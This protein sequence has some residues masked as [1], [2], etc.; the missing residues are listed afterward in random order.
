MTLRLAARAPG[1]S[2]PTAAA[3]STSLGGHRRRRAR[4]PPPRAARGRARAARP[5]LARLEPLLDRADGGARR[6]ALGRA[7]AARSV[8]L[9]LGRGGER[10][11]AEVRAQGDRQA[12]RRRARGLASTAA[13][14]ARSPSPASRRS[15]RAFEPLLAGRRVRRSRTTSRRSHAAVGA[16]DRLHPARADPGRG[17]RPSRSSPGSS[18]RPRELADEH[19]ALLVFDEMQTGVGRTGT[20]LRLGAARRAP[21]RGHARQGARE[22]AADRLPARRRRRARG[23]RARATTARTFGGNP[24]ACAAAVAVCDALTDELL[25]DVREQGARL[26]AGLAPSR[27]SP[28]CAAAACCS[29]PSSTARPAPVVDAARERGLLV[30]SR[31]RDRRFAS[32]RR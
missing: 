29:A 3:T 24:V 2:T 1:S 15:A 13:R 28:R 10:G 32:P 25:A 19:G 11:G 17:R 23:L 21:R 16:D 20:L 6:A 8:L 5:A 18:P 26:A 30:G 27:A 7:S 14:S 4:P 31:R 22:R 9:Q 12:G